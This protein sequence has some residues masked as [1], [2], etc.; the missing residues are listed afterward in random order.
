MNEYWLVDNGVLFVSLINL[1][2]DL[3][4]DLELD[5]LNDCSFSFLGL[6]LNMVSFN[7]NEL[8]FV[9]KLFKVLDIPFLIL[10]RN[11]VFL[12]I[13][14]C[15]F[16]LFCKTDAVSIEFNALVTVELFNDKLLN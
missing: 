4:I 15:S 5:L 2:P 7:D 8:E 11:R 9:K 10:F 6:N 13:S 16:S 1:P 3:D 12:L 14:S